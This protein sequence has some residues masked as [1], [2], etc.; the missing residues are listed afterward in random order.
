VDLAS[1]QPRKRATWIP[2]ALLAL[3]LLVAGSSAIL[4]RY[5]DG[6]EPLAMSFWRCTAGSLLLLPFSL[7]DLRN[8]R[9]REVIIC[10]IS[11]VFLAFHFATWLASI[12]MT[13]IAA[14]VLLVS[15]SPVFVALTAWLFFKDRLPAAGWIGIVL[16]LVG[17][18]LV[19][20]GSG[21]SGGEVDVLGNVLALIGGATAGW[22]LMAGA[23]ARRRLGILGYSV[24]TYGIAAVLLLIPIAIQGTPLV[25]FPRDTWLAIAGMIVGPQLLGHTVIN[26]ILNDIDTTTVS[27]ALL[28]ESVIAT[29]LAFLL[30][31][32]VP[33]LFVY[34]GGVVILAGIFLV[35][36]VRRPEEVPPE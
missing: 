20:A 4:V 18:A 31:D 26:Y 6:A 10:A 24:I 36:R 11:G 25:G 13:T 29:F 5:A 15:L 2:W 3:G 34:L 23:E 28:S 33:S 27:V 16:A 32:E 14:A 12:G 17:S 1:D 9:R 35:S 19:L 8:V 30:F 22:Y 7:K 21:G